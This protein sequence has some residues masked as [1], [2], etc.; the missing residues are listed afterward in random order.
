MRGRW[1]TVGNRGQALREKPVLDSGC[2]T[3][4]EGE[5]RIGECDR[6]EGLLF[7]I[8]WLME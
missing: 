4:G 8:L 3:G 2:G 7:I 1:V 6:E 5:R